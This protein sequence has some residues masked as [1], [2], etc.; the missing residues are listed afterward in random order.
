[1]EDFPIRIIAFDGVYKPREDTFLIM[2]YIRGLDLN[3]KRVLEIGC[4]TG[5]V[6]IFMAKRG[7]IVDAVDIDDRAV[8]NTKYNATLNGVS[9]NI[10]ASDLFSNVE[11]S[12]DYIIFNPPYLEDDAYYSLDP[13]IFG[14]TSLMIRFI[15]ESR[16]Y[17]KKSG[18]IF[19]VVYEHNDLDRVYRAIYRNAYRYEVVARKSLFFEELYLLSIRWSF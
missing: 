17:L 11:G 16:A 9:L 14:G 10:Y 3:D 6:S 4:G 15:D 13:A 5:I 8:E 1:M 2:D 12:Y 18:S 19:M 7:A